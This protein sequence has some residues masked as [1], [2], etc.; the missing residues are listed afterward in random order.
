MDDNET[1]LWQNA[2]S[3][4]H[5]ARN[6]LIQSYLSVAKHAANAVMRKVRYWPGIEYDDIYSGA[7][8]GLLN[9]VDHYNPAI[10]VPFSTFAWRRCTGAAIDELRNTGQLDDHLTM[11]RK[12]AYTDAVA[13]LTNELCRVPTNAELCQLLGWSAVVLA[14]VK[15][16]LDT[17]TVEYDETYMTEFA[18][19]PED[20][21]LRHEEA[22][23][24][25]RALAALSAREQAVIMDLY[26]R[27]IPHKHVAS[28]MHISQA[29]VSYL[30]M[31]ALEKLK[32]YITAVNA[33]DEHHA[34]AMLKKFNWRA[35]SKK[36]A[37]QHDKS[38]G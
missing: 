36:E 14:N 10:G 6:S 8:L 26:M 16:K 3:G 5:V 4:N 23:M 20:I 21:A 28:N 37:E 33:G 12:R 13:Q 22:E 19:S 1:Q 27:D 35:I 9:A 31:R 2:A 18:E 24:L 11:T 15:Q 34:I 38:R 29:M 17:S 25:R 30:H 32:L 7:T